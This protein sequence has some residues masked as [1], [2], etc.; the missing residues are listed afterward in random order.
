MHPKVNE[1]AAVNGEGRLTDHGKPHIDR[2]FD[3]A[4]KLI[5]D[6]VADLNAYELFLLCAAIHLHDIGNIDG[7]KN[8][9]KRI[10]DVVQRLKIKIPMEND[11]ATK[12]TI[13]RIAQAHGGTSELK[14]DND[15]FFDLKNKE[16]LFGNFIVRPARISSVLR[17]ADEL[18]DFC[19]RTDDD[20]KTPEEN[21]I[22]HAYSRTLHEC[23]IDGRSI[24]LVYKLKY[25]DTQKQLRSGGQRIYLYDEIRRR[26]EKLMR[27]MEYCSKYSEGLIIACDVHVIIRV[28]EK[29][30]ENIDNY[31]DSFKLCLRG[32]P[33]TRINSFDYYLDYDKDTRKAVA[34]KCESGKIL[35]SVVRGGTE[36]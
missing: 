8:H 27:E 4:Q 25:E 29:E 35:K 5:G 10:R 2:V 32:Y 26:L 33:D 13:I 12:E 15:T 14:K 1:G 20:I 17:F 9:E 34:P 30:N 3:C 16:T 11:S 28:S 21:E 24:Q 36:K 6:R 7:R 18:S 31:K 23:H 22:H 19:K